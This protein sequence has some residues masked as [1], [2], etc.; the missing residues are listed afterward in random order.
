MRH[1]LT[2]T[3][4]QDDLGIA[5]TLFN[6]QTEVTSEL[7]DISDNPATPGDSLKEKFTS[8]LDV[9]AR[10]TGASIAKELIRFFHLEHFDI[11][12]FL[13]KLRNIS[14]CAKL[15]ELKCQASFQNSG[16]QETGTTTTWS[17]ALV[18]GSLCI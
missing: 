12:I 2:E 5:D 15:T 3:S 7:G 9:V 16:F 13:E 4:H 18:G 14:D 17:M 8:F 10:R 11:S 1:S 6:C